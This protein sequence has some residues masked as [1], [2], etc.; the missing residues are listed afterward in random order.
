MAKLMVIGNFTE[1]AYANQLKVILNTTFPV[2]K[3]HPAKPKQDTFAG[4]SAFIK[5]LKATHVAVTS[6]STFKLLSRLSLSGSPDDNYGTMVLLPGTSIPLILVPPLKQLYSRNYGTFLAKHYLNYKLLGNC[7][8]KDKFTW[9]FITY[10]NFQ[11]VL[12][13]LAGCSLIAVDIET[14]KIGLRITSC[15]YSGL[16]PSGLSFNA[17]INVNTDQDIDF[18]FSVMK[19]LNALPNPKVTQNGQY[20]NTYFLRFNIPLVN[21]IYDTGYLMHSFCPELPKDLAFISSFFLSNFIYWKDESSSNLYEYNAKDSHNTLWVFLSQLVYLR[22]LN[23]Y[24]LDNYAEVFPV[25]Y[26]CLSAGMEGMVVNEEQM[27][28][29]FVE[30]TEKYQAAQAKLAYYIGVPNFN[31]GSFQQVGKLFKALGYPQ[32]GTDKKAL[33]NFYE[34]SEFNIPIAD[35]IK[36]YRFHKKAASTYFSFE[37]LGGRMMYMLTP[38]GPET[39]RMA[40]KSSNLWCGAQVQNFPPYGRKMVEAEPGFK[41][42]ATDK[43][44]SE[45]YCTGYIA[46]EPKLIHVV[47]TSPDFH[48]QNGSM[49]FGIPFDKLYDVETHKKL[50]VAI[51]DLAKKVNHGANYNMGANKLLEQMGTTLVLQAKQ[52]LNLPNSW[53]L[54]KVCEYLLYRFDIA[55]PRIRGEFQKELI[56]EVNLTQRLYIES[57]NHTRRTFLKPGQNKLHL[58]SCVAHKP[59]S[60]SAILVNRSFVKVWREL[61]IKKYPGQFRVKAAIHD[62]ILSICSE[63]IAPQVAQEQADLMVMPTMVEGKLMT[64]PS[65]IAMGKLWSQCK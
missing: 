23:S 13:T 40:S 52:L 56:N 43:A 20:D 2:I 18:C 15:A 1:E 59:Q 25:N 6:L 34:A 61:Q 46:K 48:C 55:Y 29:L 9:Q 24:A 62:E 38:H 14:H 39:A 42:I 37:L 11:S 60:L 65:T 16:L 63:G 35:L 57:V 21:W 27:K 7:L 64:I 50:N 12:A 8:T 51:R 47:T 32:N 5:A 33:R 36:E 26:P 31:P 54:A 45:S 4:L 19:Q 10:K 17:V 49:F 53:R 3:F 30:A 58:N 22:G 44:Q 41:F 28:A